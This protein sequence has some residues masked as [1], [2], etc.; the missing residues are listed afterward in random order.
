MGTV[1]FSLNTRDALP[2]FTMR[3]VD[4]CQ[5]PRDK[6]FPTC[7]KSLLAC[8][9]PLR[10]CGAQRPPCDHALGLVASFDLRDAG[11]I[12]RK[13]FVPVATVIIEVERSRF[14]AMKHQLSAYATPRLTPRV[15]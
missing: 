7:R 4:A 2:A 3:F 10:R 1:S 13:A 6:M 5:P 8:P 15:A 11:D 12:R 9:L 14:L